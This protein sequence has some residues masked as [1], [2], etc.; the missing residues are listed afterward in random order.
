MYASPVPLRAD[1]DLTVFRSRSS[2]QDAWLKAHANS[3][4]KAGT[5]AK[6]FVVTP[7]SQLTEVVAYYAWCMTAVNVADLPP[8]ATQGAGR[9]PQP[10][11][12]LARL[13]VDDRHE[14]RGLGAS[15][16]REVF[17]RTLDLSEQIGCRGI[18]IHAE[19]DDAVAF[20]RHL[21]PGLMSAP[22]EPHRLVILAK[23][24]GRAVE[25]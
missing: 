6:V 25:Q 14:R 22:D 21:V 17:K 24:L 2:E 20:Y 18:L 16:L 23:D 7:H 12:L 5:T 9:Y 3:Q 1:H 11:A 19:T 8:R 10:F 13:A 4:L 15:L